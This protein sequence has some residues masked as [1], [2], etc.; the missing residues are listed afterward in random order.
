MISQQYL[1]ILNK[2]WHDSTL[3]TI[4]FYKTQDEY[5]FLDHVLKTL[6][7]ISEEESE[8]IVLWLENFTE[9]LRLEDPRS[10][11]GMMRSHY[12]HQSN[13]TYIFTSNSIE[14]I[15]A[16]FNDYEQPFYHAARILKA[17]TDERI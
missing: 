8:S 9:V 3:E 1:S 2:H 15:N 17:Y 11:C 10:I 4:N 6:K 16:I 13:V 7:K 14:D 12:Q 5:S